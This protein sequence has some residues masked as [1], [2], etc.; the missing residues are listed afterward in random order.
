MYLKITEDNNV[1][2]LKAGKYIK[3]STQSCP[4]SLAQVSGQPERP[5]L[6]QREVLGGNADT[7]GWKSGKAH[8]GG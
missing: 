5:F 6:V 8:G 3:M 2:D 1:P 7:G 4:T